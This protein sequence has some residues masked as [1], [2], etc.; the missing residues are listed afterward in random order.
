V[1]S[2]DTLTGLAA[3]FLGDAGRWRDIARANNLDD[4]LDLSPGT[5]LLIPSATPGR[6]AGSRSTR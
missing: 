4:P 1:R 2:G 5:P 3:T 6:P